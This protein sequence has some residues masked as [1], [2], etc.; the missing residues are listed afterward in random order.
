MARWGLAAL[1][2]WTCSL[3]FAQS[4]VNPD[5]YYGSVIESFRKRD[6]QMVHFS[7]LYKGQ[8]SEELDVI[9]VRGGR[10]AKTRPYSTIRTFSAGDLVGLFLVS[11][12]DPA[13]KS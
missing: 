3:S 9:L 6:P 4:N 2:L 12:S 13:L 1:A 7:L 8:A 11:R 5:F 10:I